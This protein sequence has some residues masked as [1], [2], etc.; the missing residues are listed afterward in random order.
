MGFNQ[1]S[2]Q[3]AMWAVIEAAALNQKPDYTSVCAVIGISDPITVFHQSGQ[4]CADVADSFKA[5]YG[6]R[7]RQRYQ[8]WPMLP[9]VICAR[10]SDQPSYQFDGWYT[11]ACQTV[12]GSTSRPARTLRTQS[13]LTGMGTSAGPNPVCM[14]SAA[15][16]SPSAIGPH[17]RQPT[18]S[19][20]GR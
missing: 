6:E 10:G 9:N 20:C 19:A 13:Q 7:Y 2:V 1:R 14:S 16:S 3:R 8:E 17:G 5:Q 18:P 11:K 4:L 12:D 15:N